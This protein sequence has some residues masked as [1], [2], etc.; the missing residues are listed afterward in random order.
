MI[1][2]LQKNPTNK[3]ETCTCP[4]NIFFSNFHVQQTQNLLWRN[5][6][7]V[8]NNHPYN[9]NSFDLL[10]FLTLTCFVPCTLQEATWIM[11]AFKIPLAEHRLYVLQWGMN[12]MECKLSAI[13][14][15]KIKKIIKSKTWEWKV[16]T[17]TGSSLN[18]KKLDDW[19]KQRKSQE[20]Q[21]QVHKT[22][23]VLNS[24]Q[25]NTLTKSH[26]F[27]FTPCYIH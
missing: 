21:Y 5:L 25:K 3:K 26:Y 9:K 14:V 23:P 2:P 8:F 17:C 6:C 20:L 18:R 11:W 10:I 4:K 12:G 24:I 1:P 27:N 19:R 16:L 7:K 15:F 22:P 13:Y